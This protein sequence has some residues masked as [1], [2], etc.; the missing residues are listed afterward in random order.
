[1]TVLNTVN[2]DSSTFVS[3]AALALFD[4]SFNNNADINDALKLG[5][6]NENIV[7]ETGSKLLSIERRKIPDEG[8]TIFY[9]LYRMQHKNYQLEFNMDNAGEAFATTAFLEDSYLKTRTEVSRT[10]NSKIDFTVDNNAASGAT[11][12]FR[13]VFKRAV[14]FSI[15]NAFVLNSDIAVEWK[16]ADEFN[17]GQYEIERS[18]D[19]SSFAATGNVVSR[20]NSTVPVSYNWLDA[21]P[22]PG[23]YYYR[24]KCTAN[25]GAVVY[26]DVVKVK[27]VKSSPFLYVFPNP[28]TNN[29][30]QLQ[31]NSAAA[32][33]YYTRLFNSNGQLVSSKN[34]IHPGGTATHTI[35]PATELAAGFYQLEVT[36]PDNKISVIKVLVRN[37]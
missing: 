2:A 12:R 21:S 3:D 28:V 30:I 27:I 11:G 36:G 35:K 1:M 13:L 15:I 23:E 19:G 10:G 31:L 26:S 6:F 29:I 33:K 37:D 17:I 20:G 9:G 34:L 16:V 25:S 18:T 7:I 32:G 24:I 5:N 22:A 14:K 4:N 8:D